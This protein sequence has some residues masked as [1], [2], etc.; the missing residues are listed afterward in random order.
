MNTQSHDYSS[1]FYRGLAAVVMSAP[2]LLVFAAGT[3]PDGE[4]GSLIVNGLGALLALVAGALV[5]R[6]AYTQVLMNK[7]S[8]AVKSTRRQGGY[9][10]GSYAA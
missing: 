2:L 6:A 9:S 3:R 10:T 8:H 4:R 1:L 5:L 7:V